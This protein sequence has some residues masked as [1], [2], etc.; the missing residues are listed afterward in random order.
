MKELNA[1]EYGVSSRSTPRTSS[2]WNGAIPDR[3]FT[4]RLTDYGIYV[5][6][7]DPDILDRGRDHRVILSVKLIDEAY[8]WHHA[9]E[10][11]RLKESITRTEAALADREER[12][13]RIQAFADFRQV[14]MKDESQPVKEATP[15][16]DLHAERTAV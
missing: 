12:L 9:D 5:M 2:S 16:S 11:A 1:D 10:I 3:I 7:R 14:E 4:C 6:I 8:A 13:A 15:V